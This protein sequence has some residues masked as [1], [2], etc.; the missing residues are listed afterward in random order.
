MIIEVVDI[1]LAPTGV[2]LSCRS[3]AGQALVS[4][5]GDEPPARRQY[6]VEWDVDVDADWGTT[7][8][9][10]AVASPAIRM[11]GE[12]VVLRCRLRPQSDDLVVLELAD[13]LLL[14]DLVSQVPVQAWDAWVE[15]RASPSEVAIYPFDL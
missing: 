15:L 2:L 3:S 10:A 13:T 7:L 14:V 1:I 9:M 8:R 6:D 12:M 4:W 11:E 5:R